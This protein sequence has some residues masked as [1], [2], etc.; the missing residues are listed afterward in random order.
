M[1]ST[2]FSVGSG[3]LFLV[4]LLL[5]PPGG[6][7][8][9]DSSP[10]ARLTRDVRV[11]AEKIG[12]RSL[13]NPAALAQAAAAVHR[14]LADATKRPV[15]RLPYT[16]KGQIVTNLEVVLPGRDRNAAQVV[17]GAHYDS[18][19][20]TPGA[21]DNA[22]GVAALLEI[23]R[24]LSKRGHHRPIRL[25]AFVNEEPPYFKTD[26]MG[27]VVYAKHLKAK[28]VQVHAMIALD[29]LGYYS[30]AE[31]SQQYPPIIGRFYPKTAN[32]VALVG[33]VAS[34]PVLQRAKAAFAQAVKFPVETIAAPKAVQGIDFSDH[35]SFWQQGYPGFMITDTAFFR[36][37]HYHQPTDTP[38]TLDFDR[39]ATVTAGITAI[40]VALSQK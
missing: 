33:D 38:Q 3:W 9:L 16:V 14:G 24:T 4:G 2:L 37:A 40:V 7:A 18:V 1:I 36:N 20:T 12:P 21:D 39:L 10:K 32:F 6:Q 31:G 35:W 5:V 19:P 28:G 22:S 34:G 11:L 13:A 25:V 8:R 17:I 15:A 30:D 23:G 27:S 29:M 26:A